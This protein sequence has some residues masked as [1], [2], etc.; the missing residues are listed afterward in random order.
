MGAIVNGLVLHRL[1]AFGS[2]FFNFLD[3]MKPAVRLSPKATITG[4]PATARLPCRTEA[5]SIPA[6]IAT[7]AKAPRFIFWTSL[8]FFIPHRHAI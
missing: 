1:R 6:A 4:V 8:P 2:T 7:I 5:K 3:Y